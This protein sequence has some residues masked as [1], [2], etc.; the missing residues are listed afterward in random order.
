MDLFKAIFGRAAEDIAYYN[1][2]GFSYALCVDHPDALNVA[3][4]TAEGRHGI[5]RS[6]MFYSPPYPEFECPG[7][8]VLKDEFAARD[9]QR[10]VVLSGLECT[11]AHNGKIVPWLGL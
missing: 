4:E 11:L 9:I 7:Y 1:R 3:L 2:E 10:E 8:L 6:D 5:I